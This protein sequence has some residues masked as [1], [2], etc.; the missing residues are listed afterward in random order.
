M[1]NFEDNNARARSSVL[2]RRADYLQETEGDASE[3]PPARNRKMLILSAVV[4]RAPRYR[5]LLGEL[6]KV[7]LIFPDLRFLGIETTFEK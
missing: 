7:C 6:E 5:L 2:F 3:L 4:C 1:I